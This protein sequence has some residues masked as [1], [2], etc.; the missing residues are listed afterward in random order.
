MSI[1]SCGYDNMLFYFIVSN[2]VSMYLLYS[3]KF[4]Y[5]DAPL[6]CLYLCQISRQSEDAF[7]ILFDRKAQKKKLSQ[8][9]MSEIPDTI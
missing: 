3:Y 6:Y 5:Q 4:W 9:Y 1:L 2:L 7:G 8:F